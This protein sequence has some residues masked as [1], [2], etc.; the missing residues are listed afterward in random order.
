[1]PPSRARSLHR[2]RLVL[3]VAGSSALAAG[4]ID[5]TPDENQ[6]C[7]AR[8]PAFELHV[9]ASDGP[10]PAD[11][12]VEVRYAGSAVETYRLGDEPAVEPEVVFCDPVASDAGAGTHPLVIV[13]VDC[14]LWTDGAA[15][16]TVQSSRHEAVSR[17]LDADVNEC[18][19]EETIEET[20][21][22]ESTP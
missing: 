17:E 5:F 2:R 22:L 6:G 7:P 18:G 10:L 1:M 21:V 19:V 20:I 12:T 3:L 4:C 16:V 15:V 13:A 8:R 14:T 11:T 9:S